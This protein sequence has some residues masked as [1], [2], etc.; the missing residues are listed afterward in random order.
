[1]QRRT[2]KVFFS[3][4]KPPKSG[5]SS[6]LSKQLKPLIAVAIIVIAGLF[7]SRLPVFQVQNV[8]IEGIE[9]TEAID[10][11]MSFKGQS[12][13]SSSIQQKTLRILDESPELADLRCRKGIPN[14]ISCSGVLR[15]PTLVWQVGES[16]YLVDELG[17]AYK[18]VA[19]DMNLMAVEDRALAEIELNQPVV[20]SDI[21]NAFKNI[22][23]EL[24]DIGL[25]VDRFFINTSMY[26]PGVLVSSAEGSQINLSSGQIEIILSVSYPIELQTRLINRFIDGGAERATQYIDL[27]TPG[28]IYY[29]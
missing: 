2:P 15:Q 28:Y 20:N 23:K 19:E 10:R 8:E 27:R 5:G 24:S 1:M 29:Q 13:F 17:Y 22:Q 11:L 12:I 9:N 16:R 21:I 18:V 26:Y 25:V 3:S 4:Y 7:I 6:P 14:T